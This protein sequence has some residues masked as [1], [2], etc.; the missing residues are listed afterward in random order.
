LSW[1]HAQ[2]IAKHSWLRAPDLGL[3]MPLSGRIKGLEHFCAYFRYTSERRFSRP[4]RL[5]FSS[6]GG[7][8]PGRALDGRGVAARTRLDHGC[9]GE[10][11]WRLAVS[12]RNYWRR[13]H[14]SIGG[15]ERLR[16]SR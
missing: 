11:G 9:V 4:V 13:R 15:V 16:R 1:R 7:A 2:A 6:H 8:V 10:R 14:R 3:T 12:S 5:K